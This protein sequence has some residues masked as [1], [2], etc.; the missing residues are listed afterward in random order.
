MNANG[1]SFSQRPQRIAK[2]RFSFA[3]PLRLCGKSY[4]MS[5]GAGPDVR[6]DVECLVEAV[7]AW[8]QVFWRLAIAVS[9]VRPRGFFSQRPQRSR[10]RCWG[11]FQAVPIRGQGPFPSF[12]E[13]RNLFSLFLCVSARNPF[14]AISLRNHGDSGKDPPRL[15]RFPLHKG[16]VTTLSVYH[17]PL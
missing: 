12:R 8:M 4:L 15:R 2:E 16:D 17:T 6:L 13:S 14:V 3:A 11:R 9:G 10:R 7:S 1:K 5:A